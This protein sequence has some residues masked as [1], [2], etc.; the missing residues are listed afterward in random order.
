MRGR[1][2]PLKEG[3]GWMSSTNRRGGSSGALRIPRRRARSRRKMATALDS[4]SWA[5]RAVTKT[6]VK[7]PMRRMRALVVPSSISKRKL[8][9]LTETRHFFMAGVEWSKSDSLPTW[10]W[11]V[12]RGR[13]RCNRGWRVGSF[14]GGERLV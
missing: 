7:K 4:A 2:Q 8:V 5:V 12:K 13:R 3:M 10:A 11:I 1:R 14:A 6:V 9:P